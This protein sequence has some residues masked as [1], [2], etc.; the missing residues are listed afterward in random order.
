MQISDIE[1]A[2]KLAGSIL[3]TSL[4]DLAPQTRK[5]LELIYGHA[6][7]LSEEQEIEIKDV[8]LTRK[9]IREVT[10][11]GNTRLG[12]HLQR[13]VDLEYLTTHPALGRKLVYEINY[14]GQGENGD[15]FSMN[16]IDTKSLQKQVYDEVCTPLNTECT[17]HVQ[18]INAPNT[19][20]VHTSLL[21]ASS[22]KQ[23]RSIDELT[24]DAKKHLLAMPE[25]TAGDIV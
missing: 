4:D 20:H 2:N 18:D 11:W 10:A 1:T 14:Q 13:L 15:L 5:L 22:S 21:V 8:R 25:L 12:V 7:E 24:N 19:P 6:K 3:G 17:P 23:A 9:E 16:L